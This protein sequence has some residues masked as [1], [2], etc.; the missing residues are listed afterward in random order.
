[1]II[2]F[3]KMDPAILNYLSKCAQI[4]LNLN[5][6]DKIVNLPILNNIEVLSLARNYIKINRV[7][8]IG[9]ITLKYVL[10]F[11]TKSTKPEKTVYV[12]EGN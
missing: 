8:E 2:P 11:I 6:N 5:F 4:L 9:K 1:M 7:D 3:D 12:L 10:F